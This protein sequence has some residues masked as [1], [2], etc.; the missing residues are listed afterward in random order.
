MAFYNA[1]APPMMGAPLGFGAPLAPSPFLGAPL[2]APMMQRPMYGAPQVT[3]ARP[4]TYAQPQ[5]EPEP[6]QQWRKILILFGPPG[7]GKGSQAPKI[8]DAL[9]IPQLSTG[10]MLREAVSKGTEIG[11]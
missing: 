11:K 3:Y 5:Y 7:A 6:A 10:D 8:V 9:K 4:A 2:G 1:F